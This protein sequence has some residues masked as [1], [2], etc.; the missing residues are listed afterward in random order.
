[1]THLG[2][3]AE[4]AE[5]AVNECCRR[6][7]Q[8]TGRRPTSDSTPLV[9]H[10]IYRFDI[11]GLE[12]GIVNIVNHICHKKYRHA[13]ICLTN[14]SNF[15]FRIRK[16]ISLFALNKQEGK[17][18]SVYV[19]LFRLMRTLRPDIVHTR[20]LAAVD[21]ALIAK[22][23]GVPRV[24]HGEHGRDIV[25][26]HGNNWKYNL[27]R[28]FCRLFVDRYIPMSRDLA[29]WLHDRIGVPENKIAQIYNGVDVGQFYPATSN[30]APVPVS[31]FAPDGTIVIGTV[32]RLVP[33]KD[34]I[35]LVHAFL[36]L[37]SLI[38]KA[39]KRLRLALV[40]DGPLQ[41]EIQAL[42]QGADATGIAWLAGARED[43]P[44][45]LRSF[46]VFV[47][48][49]LTEGIS[50]TIL[51]A[52]ASGL[53]VVATRVGGTPEL[54]TENVTGMMVPPAQPFAMAKALQ[55]YI[56]NPILMRRH[57][58]AARERIE[59]EF[60]VKTMVRQYEAVY[61]ALLNRD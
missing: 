16:D 36:H 42:L 20:N 12:N 8:V 33:V 43:I 41:P 49:S 21:S 18:L 11:G 51:E 38:P 46:D 22:V 27:F 26:L 53:P 4:P 35:T 10:V 59:N 7:E 31:D 24:V 61:D 6:C 9:A 34:P 25:E 54:V 57:G 30:R 40:G 37:L 13:I 15:R 58:R 3:N 5:D 45:L 1:M 48:P 2:D 29:S 52:M 23:A 50:N 14:Y 56:Q 32:G 60:S 55:T 28:R 47:L 44:Q 17:D 19:K 39:R